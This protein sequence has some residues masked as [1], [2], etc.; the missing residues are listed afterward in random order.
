MSF[1]GMIAGG[2]GITPM[3]QVLNHILRDGGDASRVRTFY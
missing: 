2:T 3:W 1:A